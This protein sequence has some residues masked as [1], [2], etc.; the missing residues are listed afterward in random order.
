[1]FQGWTKMVN[2]DP[3][4]GR[5]RQAR[6]R[7]RTAPQLSD[8]GESPHSDIADTAG[9][10]QHATSGG[11]RPADAVREATVDTLFADIS[12]FQPIVND[13]YLYQVLSIRVSDGTYRDHH[14]PANY[15]WMRR[16]LDSGKLVFGIAYTYC[17]PN[18]QDNAN[19]VRSMIEANGGL[20]P[21]V[22]L[23]LDVEQ[24]GNPRG[25][26]SEW[27]NRLYWNLADYTGNPARII[28]YGNIHDLDTMWRTPPFG[29]RII[30]AAYGANPDYPGKVAHQYTDGRGF[31]GGLPEGAPPFGNCDMNSADGLDPAQFAAAC[32]ISVP[33]GDTTADRDDF[34]AAN[35]FPGR[36]AV[37]TFAGTFAAP[38]TGY[39]SDVVHAANPDLVFEVP[40]P[41]P[42]SFGQTT[43]GAPTAPS[44]A[45]SVQVAVARATKWI[46]LNPNQTF[47]IGGYGQGAAA[48][49][50]VLAEIM[51]GTLQWARPNLIGGY[52]F[53]SPWRLAGHTFPGGT[54]SGGR[55]IADINLT[56]E[57]IPKDANGFDTWWDFANPGDLYTTTPDDIAG[58]DITAVYELA[59]QRGINTNLVVTML[60]ALTGLDGPAE[61]IAAMLTN[62]VAG[63]PALAQ[64]INLTVAFA[65]TNPPTW[66]HISYHVTPALCG[67]SSVEVATGHLNR[68]A[69][70]TPTP[71]RLFS[72]VPLEKPN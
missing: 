2:R 23:M 42:W 65:D 17:R 36:H 12:E 3:A 18:W 7:R 28:G 20:H 13:S 55:G 67:Q 54:S 39:P 44:H 19:T 61:Q 8:L 41:A 22:A 53:G 37:L 49:S 6:G 1:M 10:T 48:A 14:F 46:N 45:E 31:G 33:V 58:A 35:A 71:H 34:T 51:T 24:G 64:A 50:R 11:V 25:D 38:G 72:W 30:V 32:G 47:A 40:V 9:P 52:T 70:A 15:A 43:P 27:I 16:A 57:Q 21:R 60:A 4:V 62:P 5:G 29:I 59:V 26:A 63:G 68:I 66:P 56:A 69:A